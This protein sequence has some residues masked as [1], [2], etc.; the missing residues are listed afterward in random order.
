M[1]G[2][3]IK[4]KGQMGIE[5]K[6]FWGELIASP[7]ENQRWENSCSTCQCACIALSIAYFLST[8]DSNAFNFRITRNCE[9]TFFF[10]FCRTS[11][12]WNSLFPLQS[13][14]GQSAPRWKCQLLLLCRGWEDCFTYNR[15]DKASSSLTCSK[16]Q[17]LGRYKECVP[18][19]A[20]KWW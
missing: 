3:K 11:H 16:S 14:L 18:L 12:S 13:V 7:K 6:P 4:G 17:K 19:Q 1:T 20:L 8:S 10:F 15:A 5:T 2:L 9:K